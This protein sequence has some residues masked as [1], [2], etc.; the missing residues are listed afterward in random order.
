MLAVQQ[1]LL[2][3]RSDGS[4]A[5]A[6]DVRLEDVRAHPLHRTKDHACCSVHMCVN[7]SLLALWTHS[8]CFKQCCSMDN[9]MHCHALARAYCCRTRIRTQYVL[10]VLRKHLVTERLVR[11][12]SCEAFVTQC[13]NRNASRITFV[14]Q[15]HNHNTSCEAFVTQCSN[16]NSSCATFVTQCCNHNA[17]CA[18]CVT[19]CHN[20]NALRATFVAQ[21]HNRNESRIRSVTNCLPNF[22]FVRNNHICYTC[23]GA[24]TRPSFRLWLVQ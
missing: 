23:V 15:C 8:K 17:S 9:N 7:G 11:N 18:T 1:R 14:T 21:C 6:W 10:F 3:Q 5:Y 16:Y 20:R 2:G 4:M 22:D 12:T 19:Q 24:P 13:H